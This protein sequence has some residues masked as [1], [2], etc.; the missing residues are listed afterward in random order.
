MFIPGMGAELLL[1]IQRKGVREDLWKEEFVGD[2]LP[3]C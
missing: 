1:I 2:I 3:S